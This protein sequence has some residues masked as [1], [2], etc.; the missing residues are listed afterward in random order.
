MIGIYKVIN[1]VNSKVYIGQSE[2]IERRWEKHHTAPF[3]P[4]ASQYNGPF[5][6]AIRKYGIENFHFEVIEQCSKDKLDE[7]ERYW[8]KHY[9]TYLGFKNCKGYNLT[10][11]GQS[12][13]SHY[14]SYDEVQEIQNTLLTTRISQMDISKKYGVS[15]MTISDINRGATWVD[16][17]LE[18]P[19]RTKAFKTNDKGE[20]ITYQKPC[21]RCGKMID[22]RS[23][24]CQDCSLIVRKEEFIKSLPITKDELKQLLLDNNGSFAKVGKMFNI[25]DNGLRKWCKNLDLPTHAKDYKQDKS[26]T[27]KQQYHPPRAVYMLDKETE[28]VLKEFSCYAE[29]GRFLG[30]KNATHIGD[31]ANGKRKTAYGYKWRYVE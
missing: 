16:E 10:L 21:P 25:S 5:Y 14:L 18:Y 27:Q 11:G 3:N 23:N 22:K 31:V 26:Q 24:F 12:S 6:R 2:H 9:H 7:R 13:A 4:N 17:E 29:A 8:I 15:Q 28:E 30:I 1:L 20:S 19:L